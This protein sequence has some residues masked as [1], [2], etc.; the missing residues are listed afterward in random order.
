MK[1]ILAN[2]GIAEDGKK[3]LEEAGFEV[4]TDKIAQDDLKNRINDFDVLIV[5]SATKVTREVM[6]N[7]NRLKLVVRAGVGMDNID[8]AYAR[9]KEIEV[10]NTPQSSSLPVA[11][12]VFAHLF[13]LARFLHLSNREM[14]LKGIQQFNNLKK[15][16]SDGVELRGKTLGI[17][18]FG[19]IGQETAKIALGLGMHVL[20][21][22]H[23]QHKIKIR[24]DH[25]PFKPVPVCELEMISF[26]EVIS[27]SDFI[28]LH[29][30]FKAGMA[31]LFNDNTFAKMKDGAGIINCARG[32][33]IDEEALLRAIESGKILYAG[34]DVFE[35]EP[36][37][38]EA[39]L[40]NEHISLTPHIGA[41][42][43]EGQD[44]IGNEVAEVIIHKMK[45]KSVIAGV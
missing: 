14:P 45:N 6:E 16:Y 28:S 24:F 12:L 26:D 38:K 40:N 34:L 5:R 21:H 36:N 35:N 27:K 30:P 2:D 19:R 7:C 9:E 33:V 18:G 13:S 23:H 41:S 4:V 39:L 37:V 32:G 44:R 22:D 31:P 29:V 10:A 17:I 42:T 3:I 20:V 11:E 8:I 15:K 43:T 1:R 25:L